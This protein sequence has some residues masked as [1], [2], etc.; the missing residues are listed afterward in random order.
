MPP[1]SEDEFNE[2]AAA[3]REAMQPE[4][5]VS[6][7]PSSRGAKRKRPEEPSGS[8]DV[9]GSVPLS[10]KVSTGIQELCQVKRKSYCMFCDGCLTKGSWKFTIALRRN[11]PPKSAHVHC[12]D[13]M[14]RDGAGNS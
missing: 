1:I 2:A 3:Q 12:L 7:A 14:D 13:G 6:V 8:K 5:Q 10:Y 4:Q 11:A 9:P